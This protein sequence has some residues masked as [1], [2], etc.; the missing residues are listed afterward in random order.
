MKETKNNSGETLLSK[1]PEPPKGLTGWPWT[2]ET[3]K[4]I[5]KDII[6]FPLISIVTP[7]FN[8]GKFIEQT[9][10][11]VLLQNYPNLEYII[12]DGGSTDETVNVIRKYEKWLKYWVSEKDKGQ[13]NAINKG[14]RKCSGEIFNWLNSDDYYH[15]DC[16][17][18]IAENFRDKNTDIVSGKYRFFY[19]NENREKIIDLKMRAT[20]EESIAL[21]AI[22][23]PSTFFRLDVIKS[24]GELNE[25]FNYLMDQDIWKKYLFRYGQNKIKITDKVLVSFRYHSGSKTSQYKFL[26]EYMGIYCSIAAKAGMSKHTEAMKKVYG[27]EIDS[28]FGFEIKFSREDLKLAKKVINSLFLFNA[29]KA[30]TEGNTSQLNLWLKTLDSKYLN[31]TQKNDLISLKVKSKL[32]KYRLDPI[33]K[34]INKRNSKA[35]N[36]KESSDHVKITEQA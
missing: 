25:K 3:D 28:G 35:K 14:I 32:H 5:Y 10:R 15:K 18:H 12:I 8:Q 24:L 17:S 22:N 19:E 20:L 16:F 2:E 23:Q 34:F 36:K 6:S 29:K 33:I 9:I 7:S 27:K 21:V 26:N 1:L 30:Y 13:T 31:G 11:S 4:R